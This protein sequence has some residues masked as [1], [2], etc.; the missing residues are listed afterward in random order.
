MGFAVYI[1]NLNLV[2]DSATRK[3]RALDKSVDKSTAFF[4]LQ[5][6]TMQKENG[7]VESQ[8]RRLNLAVVKPERVPEGLLEEGRKLRKAIIAASENALAMCEELRDVHAKIG[9]IVGQSGESKTINQL[10]K[11]SKRI[12]GMTNKCATQTSTLAR[13]ATAFD[14]ALFGKNPNEPPALRVI[15]C[16]AGREVAR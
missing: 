16:K 7:N 5:E 11:V 12:V 13:A 3:G 1:V 10:Y 6:D 2:V 8:S 15:E 14:I 9:D 4:R